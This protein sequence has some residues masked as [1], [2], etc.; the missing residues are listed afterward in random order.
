MHSNFFMSFSN[1]ETQSLLRPQ[2]VTLD[3]WYAKLC[4]GTSIGTQEVCEESGFRGAGE[5][6]GGW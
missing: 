4:S 5:S 2:T 6:I 3:P 1:F